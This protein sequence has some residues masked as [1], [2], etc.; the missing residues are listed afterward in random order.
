VGQ[1]GR[2]LGAKGGAGQRAPRLITP[3]EASALFGLPLKSV[4]R[5]FVWGSP[6]HAP[7]G[8]PD[9]F[10]VWYAPLRSADLIWGKAAARRAHQ[11]AK[12]DPASAAGR[13][14]ARTIGRAERLRAAI[15]EGE[16]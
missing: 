7:I 12:P 10:S 14:L 8:K 5:A 2:Q 9:P 11:L 1:T 13:A 4:W 6:D 15:A 16:A 3:L